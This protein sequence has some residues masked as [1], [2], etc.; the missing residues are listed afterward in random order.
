[1]SPSKDAPAEQGAETRRMPV[2]A[3]HLPVKHFG[4]RDRAI[5]HA[6]AART[7]SFEASN[8]TCDLPPGSHYCRRHHKPITKTNP[9]S[10]TG[11]S[12]L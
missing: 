6:S 11:Y 8:G 9:I 4:S 10:V 3:N 12:L 5:R 1:L 7:F 2:A